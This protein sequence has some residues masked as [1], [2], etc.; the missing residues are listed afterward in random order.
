MA[1]RVLGDLHQDGLA[2]GQHR[3]DLAR[4]ALLV[5]QRGPVDLAGVQHGVA[6]AADVDERGLHRRQDV[7]DPAEVDVAD[8]RGLRLAGDVVLDEHLVLEHADL[9]QV[10]ALADHHDP[11]DGLAA[12]QE[13]G[14]ADD[15]GAAASGLA[16]LAAALL[17]GL[18]PGRPGERGD[19]VLGRARLALPGAPAARAALAAGLA[20][21][22]VG[23]GRRSRPPSELVVVGALVGAAAALAGLA[24]ASAAATAAAAG[25]AVAGLAALGLVAVGLVAGSAGGVVG[26]GRTRLFLA[27]VFFAGA[28]LAAFLA[29][30][31]A[32]SPASAGVRVGGL[33]GGGLL[34]RG[35]PGRLHRR[36]LGRLEQRHR[37][38]RRRRPRPPRRPSWRPSWPGPSSAAFLAGAFL[39]GGLLGRR[40]LGGGLLRRRLLGGLLGGRP[41]WRVRRRG[42]V[43]RVVVGHV[44]C[45]SARATQ[46]D[47]AGST[48]RT[49]AAPRGATA[50]AERQSLSW[51][52]HPARCA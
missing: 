36:R 48:P 34:G 45:S 25:A 22:G 23:L 8:Q 50:G 19:L 35:L 24:T 47:L 3:L 44:W 38:G 26:L 52:R 5:A 20:V 49:R 30:F 14:L 33:C 18:E 10:V 1:D 39:A 29:G 28:F 13:L 7:L 40:L 9:G 42:G 15:R 12:G 43:D 2:R 37:A 41:S 11:V 46:G 21:T 31:S 51:R 6:A 32:A 16:A 27:A 4:L 17:L